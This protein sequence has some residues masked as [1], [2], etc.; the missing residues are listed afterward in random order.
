[1]TGRVALTHIG[2]DIALRC[3]TANGRAVFV[4]LDRHG[5]P[6]AHRGRAWPH[7]LRGVGWHIAAIKHEISLLPLEGTTGR[8]TSPGTTGSGLLFAHFSNRE[9]DQ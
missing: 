3:R 1:V 6:T 9:R 5:N 8:D 2:S 7:E 4:Y